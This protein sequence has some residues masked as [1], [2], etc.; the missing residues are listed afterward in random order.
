MNVKS[1]TVNFKLKLFIPF[2]ITD[3]NWQFKDFDELCADFARNQ[4]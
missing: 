2:E 3:P 4:N 1:L